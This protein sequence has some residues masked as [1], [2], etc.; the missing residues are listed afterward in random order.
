LDKNILGDKKEKTQASKRTP[1]E[2]S[3]WKIIQFQKSMQK[4]MERVIKIPVT[5][6]TLEK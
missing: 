3:K 5:A 4:P 2:T 1:R 6:K